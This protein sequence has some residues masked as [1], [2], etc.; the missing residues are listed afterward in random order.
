MSKVEY[1]KL[2]V[3]KIQLLS[4]NMSFLYIVLSIFGFLHVLKNF[5]ILDVAPFQENTK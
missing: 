3:L 1:Q 2:Y 4:L 5:G